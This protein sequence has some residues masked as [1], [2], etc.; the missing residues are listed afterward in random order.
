MSNQ[1]SSTISPEAGQFQ[2]QRDHTTKADRHPEIFSTVK[3]LC[4]GRIGEPRILSFGCS[5]GEEPFTLATS[6]FHSGKIFALDSS[7]T[8]LDIARR[9]RSIDD[10]IV[11]D[12]S[13]QSTLAQYGP[14]DVIFAMSVLCRWPAL[15]EAEDASEL[16]PFTRYLEMV[17]TLHNNLKAGGFLVI[18]NA[19]YNFVDT[20]L[21]SFYEI[22][23]APEIKDNGYV[24]HFDRN[25]KAIP[26]YFATDVIYRKMSTSHPAK[27]TRIL[28]VGD[29]NCQP[30]GAICTPQ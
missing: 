8:V 4:E 27:G 22:V 17:T 23:L 1:G 28:R 16:F 2:I 25:C 14:Y 11:Y 19:N 29:E 21:I 9:A 6:Y 20:D 5:T 13:T 15:S 24:R 7:V 12:V 26:D 3:R 10:R 18:Y 30:L